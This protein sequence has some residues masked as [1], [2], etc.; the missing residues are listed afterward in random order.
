MKVLP[1]GLA[2]SLV[3][4]GAAQAESIAPDAVFELGRITVYGERTGGLSIAADSVSSEALY[5]FNR[6]SLDDAVAILPGVAASN[7]GGSRNE[8]LIF[9][10]GFDRF[11]VPLSID[12]VRVYL[13]A[14]NRLD[15]ARFLTPD[16]AEVQVAKAH[17]SVIDGPGAMGGAI[18]LVTRKPVR[19]FETEAIATMSLDSAGDL[20]A[21]TLFG[22]AGTRQDKWY[23]Q[24]SGA[25][26]DRDHFRVADGFAPTAIEN[27]G[28]RANSATE[29][30]RVN[31]KLGFAPDEGQEYSINYTRQEGAKNAPYHV[32]DPLNT[33]R[34]W[35]WPYWN[36]ESLYFLSATDLGGA[37]LRLKAY[38]NT[39]DNLLRSFDSA[40]QTTQ[41]LPRAFDSYYEDAAYG[42]AVTL[43]I[44]LDDRQTLELAAHYRRDEHVEW[45]TVFNPS[46]FT[47]PEQTSIEDTFSLAAAHTLRLNDA[48]TLT[49]GLSYDWRDLKRAEDFAS[50]SFVHYALQDADAWNVQGALTYDLGDDGE[51]F[52]RVSARTR[53]PTLFERFSSRF[54][55]ATSNPGL[56]PERAF[57]IDIGG[58]RRFGGWF[59]EGAVF[60]SDV[61][62]LIVAVPIVFMGQPVTQSRN[63]GTAAFYGFEASFDVSLDSDLRLGGNYTFVE[64]DVDNPVNPAFEATGVPRHKFFAY[65]EWVPV[66]GLT[67]TP[68]V[69]ASSDRWTVTT[70]GALYYRT[71]ANVLANLRLDLELVEGVEL[72][73]AARNLLDVDYALTDG[74]PEPGRT[75][76]VSLRARL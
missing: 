49:T 33:Q 10:R 66:A 68:N 15:F 20:A 64:R 71:G 44:A 41:T 70:N 59:I 40:A 13:P 62:D 16:I 24:M 2:A 42:G 1:L 39:F 25:W 5:R 9:V 50:G 43:A 65:L 58:A 73:L 21:T 19:E 47:E 6:E 76:A 60:Y 46:T 3:V 27:G 48:L 36:I 38:Y 32:S 55:G 69:E 67:I 17:A 75:F 11:Q 30:W 34:F 45:Q 12:G 28:R 7:S 57:N 35:T 56:A 54:G 72:G 23:A 52:A 37:D 74:F 22:L 8:R 18:N 29:D 31:V 14:D 63:V 51:L 26:Q 61:D 4:G 53:F